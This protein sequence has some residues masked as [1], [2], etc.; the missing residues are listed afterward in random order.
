M[1][2]A[3]I[4]VLAMLM[5]VSAMTFT[6]AAEEGFVSGGYYRIALRNSSKGICVNMSAED[7]GQIFVSDYWTGVDDEIWLLIRSEEGAFEIINKHSNKNLDV[8]N[9]SLDKDKTLIQYAYS[10]AKNQQWI[11]EPASG[12]GYYIK[13]ANSELY[14]TVQNRLVAQCE[15]TD[16]NASRQIFDV[17]YLVD[18]SASMPKNYIIK[19]AGTNKVL[20]PS[21][22][23]NGAKLAAV[24]YDSSKPDQIW[25]MRNTGNEIYKAVNNASGYG[26]DVSGNN[27]NV[28][29]AFLTY[30]ANNGLNQRFQF[31]DA[32]DGKCYIIP[33][34][35][36]LYATLKDD[37]TIVQDELGA[38]GVQL[39]EL[40]IVE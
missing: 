18:G 13:N 34:H 5:A 33:Q 17:N 25:F 6:V 9:G 8:P 11:F 31:L 24:E 37:G 1:K 12:G 38:D 26:I 4:V 16:E 20:A 27:K 3:L 10:G 30:T 15:K 39:F 23:N 22:D 36:L 40:V 2:K 32:G 35:S 7:N 29:S 19:V 28:G 14:L 21:A